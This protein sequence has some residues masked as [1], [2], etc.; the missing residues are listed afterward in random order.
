MTLLA[1]KIQEGRYPVQVENLAKLLPDI[2]AQTSILF[3]EVPYRDLKLTLALIDKC[4][5]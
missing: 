2:A 4:T 1:C 3:A 5:P